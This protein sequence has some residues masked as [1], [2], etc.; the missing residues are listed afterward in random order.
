MKI[1]AVSTSLAQK[2]HSCS[3]LQNVTRE[4]RQYN[5]V[6][7]TYKRGPI[8]A[9]RRMLSNVSRPFYRCLSLLS[10]RIGMRSFQIPRGRDFLFPNGGM[11]SL[12]QLVYPII[13]IR[14]IIA[15]WSNCTKYIGVFFVLPDGTSTLLLITNTVNT[16]KGPRSSL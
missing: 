8:S 14:D 1:K 6:E 15:F 10:I 5:I 9:K 16:G 4:N 7:N 11:H 3:R 13:L 12:R 2:Q